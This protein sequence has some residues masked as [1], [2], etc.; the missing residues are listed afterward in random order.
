M[1]TLS[2]RTG[3]SRRPKYD[4]LI[5]LGV[6]VAGHM[7]S[8]IKDPG[9]NVPLLVFQT[10]IYSF[11]FHSNLFWQNATWQ[12]YIVLKCSLL[13]IVCAAAF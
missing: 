5:M 4:W 9:G 6:Q 7:H 1:T 11:W 10:V 13:T 8:L 3:Q 2:S 12:I